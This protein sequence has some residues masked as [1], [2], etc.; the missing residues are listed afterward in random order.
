[1][2]HPA[3]LSP[4]SRPETPD[5]HPLCGCRDDQW[6]SPARAVTPSSGA[7][8][9]GGD[10]HPPLCGVAP[11]FIAR[12]TALIAVGKRRNCASQNAETP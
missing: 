9:L 7:G 8:T 4:A 10:A 6:K 12:A 3:I 5:A 2:A 1:M 11:V